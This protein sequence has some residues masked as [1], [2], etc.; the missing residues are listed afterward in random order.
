MH[1]YRVVNKVVQIH[2]SSLTDRKR[3]LDLV[4]I[5]FSYFLLRDRLVLELSLLLHVV[6]LENALSLDDLEL[7]DEVIELASFNEIETSGVEL[8]NIHILEP[9]QVLEVVTEAHFG[10]DGCILL[11]VVDELVRQQILVGDIFGLESPHEV[12]ANRVHFLVLDPLPFLESA[13]Q[14]SVASAHMEHSL[15]L[16]YLVSLLPHR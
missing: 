6:Q 16:S 12:E 15:I 9:D 2:E 8:V 7:L 3:D 11:K 1:S 10:S 4:V 14:L 5:D 13:F